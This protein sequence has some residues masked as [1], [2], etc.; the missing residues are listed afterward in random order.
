M[1]P[2]V[3]Q[4]NVGQE[5]SGAGSERTRHV[6]RGC[7]GRRGSFQGTYAATPP[8]FHSFKWSGPSLPALL[9][10]CPMFT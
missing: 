4:V 10:P 1:G 2:S 6:K 9:A 3:G 7:E 5:A 8:L